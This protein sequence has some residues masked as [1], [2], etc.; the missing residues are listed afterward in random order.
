M[1]ALDLPTVIVVSS[2]MSGL[3]AL[4]LFFMRRSYPPHI[5]G[6]G[7]WSIAAALWFA[8]TVFFVSTRVPGVPDSVLIY[9][10]NLLLLASN[11]FYLKG[12]QHFGERPAP[13]GRW[14]AFLMVMALTTIWLTFGQTEYAPRLLVMILGLLT[15]YVSTLVA[16]LRYPDKRLP[17]YLIAGVLC[18]HIALILVRLLHLGEV[19]DFYEETLI[20]SIY[21][22]SFAIAQLMYSI[23]A[24]L[25][26]TDRLAMENQRQAHFDHLTGIHNRRALLQYCEEE[27]ARAARTGRGAALLMMDID[28]FKQI[29]DNHGHQHGDNVLRHFARQVSALLSPPS[30]L[31]RYGGEEFVLMLP[32]TDHVN[33][34]ALAESIHKTLDSG[35]PFDCKLSIGM[36]TWQA[37]DT[38]ETMLARAD[39]ALY[40]AKNGGRN[41]TCVSGGLARSGLRRQFA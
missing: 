10:A 26:A 21:V 39:S 41:Q 24:I 14:I 38:I 18:V 17:I 8:T 7:H 34:L 23:G 19:V 37:G 20:Q 4:V 35:H 13:W 27:L 32:E 40:T 1:T 6:L 28:H 12:L 5:H 33:A 2:L 36:T 22:G 16:L 31:G 30:R 3:V 29:N 11:I 9:A 15:I 25:L